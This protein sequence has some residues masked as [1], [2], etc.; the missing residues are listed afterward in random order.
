[1]LAQGDLQGLSCATMQGHIQWEGLFIGGRKLTVCRG[2]YCRGAPCRKLQP[3]VLHTFSTLCKEIGVALAYRCCCVL[4]ASKL[5]SAKITLSSLQANGDPG[6]CTGKGVVLRISFGNFLF[7]A[8]HF[9][10]LLGCR[11]KKDARQY[12]HTGCLPLQTLL[13]GGLI[14]VTFL[15]PNGVFY[16]WG[17]VCHYKICLPTWNKLYC[18][19]R[20]DDSHSMQSRA[21]V[22]LAENI[23]NSP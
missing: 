14:G 9:V 3:N 16:V 11:R 22:Q 17:Q 15:M 12:L 20:L 4:R 1:M 21:Y 19:D 2:S 10:L 6:L 13:W 7:F 18:Q 23:S 8:A 5:A